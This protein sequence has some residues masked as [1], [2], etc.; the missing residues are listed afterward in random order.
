MNPNKK[1]VNQNHKKIACSMMFWGQAF[2]LE[3]NFY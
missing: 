1:K 2:S 3:N